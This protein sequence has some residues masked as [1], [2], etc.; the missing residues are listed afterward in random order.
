MPAKKH[1][2]ISINNILTQK[3]LNLLI[4]CQQKQTLFKCKIEENSRNPARSRHIQ[5]NIQVRSM[6]Q[7]VDRKKSTK[8]EKLKS[9]SRGNCTEIINKCFLLH[10]TV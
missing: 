3:Q 5:K 8:I 7:F 1:F 10:N 4:K 2:H 9:S 6:S